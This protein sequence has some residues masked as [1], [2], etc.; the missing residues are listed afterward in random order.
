MPAAPLE[1]FLRAAA[2][3]RAALKCPCRRERV[4]G[5]ARAS[6]VTA[7]CCLRQAYDWYAGSSRD[8]HYNATVDTRRLLEPA[9]L[10]GED[11]VAAFHGLLRN[12]SHKPIWNAEC[13]S[14]GDQGTPN[15]TNRFVDGFW[16]TATPWGKSSDTSWGGGHSSSS[17][18]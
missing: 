10:D 5:A 16:Y 9:T 1:L 6:P 3:S 18:K 11:A 8:S 17:G 7:A 15:A 2:R 4:S 13:G 14:F 12:M